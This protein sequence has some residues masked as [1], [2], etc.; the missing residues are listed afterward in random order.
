MHILAHH[1]PRTADPLP[2]H[3]ETDDAADASR[4]TARPL[5]PLRD[6]RSRIDTLL[7]PASGREAG[8]IRESSERVRE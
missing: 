8:A 6:P 3:D 7:T 2:T 1:T 4:A 5:Q